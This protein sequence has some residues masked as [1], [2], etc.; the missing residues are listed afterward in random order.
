MLTED[1]KR[2]GV[3]SSREFLRR[4]ADE[5]DNFLNSIVTGDETLAYHF[6]PETKQQSRQWRHPS[7]N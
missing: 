6:T 4:Y 3:D 7:R 5:K 1:H 2:Q